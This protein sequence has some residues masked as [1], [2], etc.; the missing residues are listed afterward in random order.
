MFWSRGIGLALVGA[1]AVLLTDGLVQASAS[2]ARA[3]SRTGTIAF[4]RWSPDAYA[5]GGP[6]LFAIGA[7]GRGLRRLTPPG[8]NGYAWS[9]DGSRI[10]Y[11]DSGGVLWLVRRDGTGRTRVWPSASHLWCV[12]VTWSSDGKTLAVTAVGRPPKEAPPAKQLRVFIVPTDGGAPRRLRS[13]PAVFLAWSPQG[14]EIAYDSGGGGIWRISSR[15]GKA[16]W[17]V[18]WTRERQT[19]FGGPQWS[20][21]GSRLALVHGR[22]YGIAVVRPDGTGLHYVTT[23]AYNEYGFAWSPDSR[24]ILYGRENREGIYVID[25]DGRNDHRVT[26][27]SPRPISWGALA[28]SPDGRSIAYNT[29]RTGGG[30][31]YLIDADGHHKTRLT[32]SPDIDVAPSWM[33]R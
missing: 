29:N 5:L 4:L 13:G 17:V 32:N 24:Q 26:R 18:G 14:G 10:A 19:G 8:V 21:D 25:A 15:G 2:E 22:Y 3:G 9:P 7:D 20:P 33:A 27:D 23:H 28:W 12:G 1:V 6:A 30:D 31:I 16:Q 11:H